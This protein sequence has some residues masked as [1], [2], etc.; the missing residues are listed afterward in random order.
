MN[1]CVLIMTYLEGGT[2]YKHKVFRFHRYL[3]PKACRL[4][5]TILSVCLHSDCD[6]PDMKI[7]LHGVIWVPPKTSDFGAF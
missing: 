4:F 5:S 6:Q 7:S 3:L 2:Q 1:I